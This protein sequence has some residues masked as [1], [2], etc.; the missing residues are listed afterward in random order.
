M[1]FAIVLVVTV[2]A[3]FA[4]RDLIHKAPVVFYAL[5]VVVDVLYLL[6]SALDVPFWLWKISFEL[7][8]ECLLP[9]SL[10]VVVMYIGCFAR[11]SKISRWLRPIRAELSIMACILAAGHMAAYM[12][13]YVAQIMGG[14][15]RANVM[16]AFAVALALLV[17]LLVLGVTS[18]NAVKRRM[19]KESWAKLQKWAYVFFGLVYVHLMFMLTPSA[20]QGGGAAQVSVAVYTVVFGAYAVARLLR[21]A[22]DGKQSV[23]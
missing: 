15:A 23:A 7:I 14:N 2:L 21:A 3:C 19:K 5:A 6:V 20:L 17:L 1:T 13:L 8:Q 9:L 18:F 22:R 4:L 11:D 16:A 10:F 12:G